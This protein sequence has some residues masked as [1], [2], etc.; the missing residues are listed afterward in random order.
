[1]DAEFRT[2]EDGFAEADR[3]LPRVAAGDRAAFEIL[4][5]DTAPTLMGIC[6]RVLPDRSEAEDVLQDVFVLVWGKAAQF[7]PARSRA[8]GWLCSIARHRAIDRL[9]TLPAPALRASI[10]WADETADPGPSPATRADAAATRVRLDDCID[11]LDPRRQALIRTAF[12]EGATYGELAQR[13]GSPLG[14]IKSWIRRALQQLKACL[15]R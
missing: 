2:N 9:R 1:M 8:I 15:E 12:Y 10:E 4:Y 7:D 3:L 14:S 6:L 13:S 5:R 11:E